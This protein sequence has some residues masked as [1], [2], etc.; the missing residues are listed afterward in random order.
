MV[1]VMELNALVG[2]AQEMIVN[3]KNAA[4]RIVTGIQIVFVIIDP[5]C[6]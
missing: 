2:R 4:T 3:V 6:P 1:I 5:I